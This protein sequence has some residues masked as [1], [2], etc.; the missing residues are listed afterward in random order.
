MNNIFKII[1]ICVIV[2]IAVACYYQFNGGSLVS[3]TS[4]NGASFTV[5]NSEE[6]TKIQQ[7]EY[8]ENYENSKYHFSFKYPKEFKVTESHQEKS[9]VVTIQNT[10]TG[11]GVQ[12]VISSYGADEDI[13]K[14]KIHADIPDLTINSEQ[15]IQIG[16]NRKGLA[17]L[18]DNPAFGGKSR[19]V[20]FIYGG[21]LYQISTYASQDALL[22]GVFSN[23][24]FGK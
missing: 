21:N 7:Y 3:L 17:F 1:G 15:V 2:L 5:Q 13:T 4:T 12:V 24:K 20:W 16:T 19:D 22:K 23:W 9:D 6:N 8:T 18:S 14:E 10:E 11:L